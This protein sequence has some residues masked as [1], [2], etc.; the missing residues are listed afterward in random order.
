MDCS[1]VEFRIRCP[2]N[3]YLELLI[4][5]WASAI[6]M[7]YTKDLGKNNDSPF[8]C[9]NW[10]YNVRSSSKKEINPLKNTVKEI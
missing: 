9:A 5:V 6:K 3:Q 7:N 1:F 2:S 10:D 4:G 8:F